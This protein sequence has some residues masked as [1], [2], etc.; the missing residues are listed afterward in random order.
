MAKPTKNQ[1]SNPVEPSTALAAFA[2]ISASGLKID[3][4][5]TK[6]DLIAIRMASE[7]ARIQVDLRLSEEECAGLTK[8]ITKVTKQRDSTLSDWANSLY[9]GDALIAALQD[10]GFKDVRFSVL[11]SP[12]WNDNTVII[13]AHI[14]QKTGYNNDLSTT[15]RTS[16][17]PADIVKLNVQYTEA[18]EKLSEAMNRAV[19]LRRELADLGTL[20][21]QAKAQFAEL[22]LGQSEAG[23]ALLDNMRGAKSLGQL[24]EARK[25]TK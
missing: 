17:L 18:Q 24:V 13:D 11:T 22:A 21:R 12:N 5:V 9:P 10:A 2:D 25:V 7:E 15:Q 6:D 23:K 3:M 1:P 8:L 19:A 14:K 4:N 20:E 16:K